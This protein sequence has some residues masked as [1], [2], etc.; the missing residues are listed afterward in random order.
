MFKDT[1]HKLRLQSVK[2]IYFFK[3]TIFYHFNY[4]FGFLKSDN[5]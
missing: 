5:L 4:N 2:A 1:A 3:R